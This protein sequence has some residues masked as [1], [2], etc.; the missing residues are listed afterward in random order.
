MRIW[1]TSQDRPTW[2]KSVDVVEILPFNPNWRPLLMV[3]PISLWDLLPEHYAYRKIG[4]VWSGN[5]LLSNI[6]QRL[7]L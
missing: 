5:I 2:V 6:D 7:L 3:L 4:L 1:L